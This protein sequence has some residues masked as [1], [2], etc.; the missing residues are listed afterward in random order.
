[1][2]TNYLIAAEV[3]SSEATQEALPLWDNH[4]TELSTVFSPMAE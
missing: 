2:A 3:T 1:M 4:P